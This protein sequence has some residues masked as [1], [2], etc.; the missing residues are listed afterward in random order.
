L[1]I[2]WYGFGHIL[3][4][5]ASIGMHGFLAVLGWQL[6][7]FA[8][9]GLCW[10]VLRPGDAHWRLHV[11]IWGRMVRDAAGQCL[12][13]SLVGGFVLGARALTL[14]GIAWPDAAAST[15]VD[16]SAEFVAQIGLVLIGVGILSARVPGASL[17][18]PIC[19]GL[20]ISVAAAV[21]LVWLQRGAGGPLIRLSRRLLGTWSRGA[22][23]Q[24]A[25][26]QL[27]LA[28][29]YRSP[30]RVALCA[31]LHLVGW[32]GTG[33]AS[34]I[35][36]RLLGAD[37]DFLGALGIEALL[38]AVLALAVLVPGYAGVQE[39][40]YAGLSALFGQPPELAL[41]VSLLRRAR[42]IAL[43]VP[44]LLLWQASEVR[45][46]QRKQAVLF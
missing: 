31:L 30:G 43:G 36:F 45:A 41:S 44:I 18:R 4:A 25:A 10:F 15:V 13:F 35:A 28:D 39:A 22:E 24:M 40:A 29:I 27:R 37:I 26:I 11:L 7:L 2:G 19:I 3:R 34:W 12:P 33:V 1:L 38:H 20:A 5:T 6:V 46:R 32:F 17:I 21:A 23:P 14:D 42:D 8:L 16:L 9:L